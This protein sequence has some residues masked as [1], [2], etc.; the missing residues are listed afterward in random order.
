MAKTV[1]QLIIDELRLTYHLENCPLGMIILDE[2]QNII[3]WSDRATEIFGWQEA[4]VIQR[5]LSSLHIVHEEEAETITKAFNEIKKGHHSSYQA[6][7]RNYTKSGSVIYCDWY[8]SA[9]KDE[10]GKIM[11]TL[12]LVLDITDNK[13]AGQSLKKSQQQ[14][15]LIYNSAID[16]MWLIDIE[17]PDTFRFE[18]INA[19]FTTVTGLKR[20]QVVGLL[21]EEVLPVS[22]HEL[23]RSKYNEAIQTGKVIDYIEIAEHPAGKKVGEIR[24]IPVKNE[25]GQYTKI[26]GIAHDITEERA[27]Q[28]KLNK[29]RDEFNKKITAAAIKGQEMERSNVSRELHDNVN[30]VLTTVKLYTEL[31]TAGTVDPDVILPKCTLLLNETI[32]EIRNLSKKLSAPS[33]GDVGIKD[34]LKDLVESMQET[35]EGEIKLHIRAASCTTIDN[36]LHL[37]IYRIAQEHLTNILKHAQ[38]KNVTIHID[39][40][41]GQ[42]SL[43]ITDDGR[44]FDTTKKTSGIGI[45][46]MT[47]RAHILNG[48]FKIESHEGRG[49]TLS[50]SF[51]V[52]AIDGKCYPVV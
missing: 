20:E 19:S 18:N 30:Q 49:C 27:L 1:L 12:S 44:G 9:L 11:S 26:V 13:A 2:H 40:V 8:N 36:E 33:L 35:L 6:T 16:P 5:S 3:Y 25:K 21:I 45:T 34:T 23:V 38:A 4:E 31:C 43:T 28:D 42:L 10:K 22:S 50:V 47:S 17:G 32:N 41:D 51:P 46:N 48:S 14:L 37:T 29:E 52:E 24:V 39:A 7:S 15:S